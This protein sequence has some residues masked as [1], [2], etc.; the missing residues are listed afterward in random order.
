MIKEMF[1][2][3]KKGVAFNLLNEKSVKAYD[4]QSFDTDEMLDFC[5]SVCVDSTLRTDY[6]DNDFTIYMRK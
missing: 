4:L 5:R 3:S 2:L 1:G 6:L